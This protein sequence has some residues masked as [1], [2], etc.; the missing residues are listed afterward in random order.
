MDIRIPYSAYESF[1][2]LR[3][4]LAIYFTCRSA[5]NSLYVFVES[6]R[7]RALRQSGQVRKE[8]ATTNSFGSCSA[9]YFI[10]F[11]IFPFLSDNAECLGNSSALLSLLFL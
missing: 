5:S 6:R 9:F 4:H 1:E 11:A 10:S 3:N 7:G 2:P 8:A